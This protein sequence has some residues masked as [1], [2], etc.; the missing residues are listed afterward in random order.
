MRARTLILAAIATVLLCS[1]C[2]WTG[3][4]APHPV[5]AAQVSDWAKHNVIDTNAA[6]VLVTAEWVRVYQAMLKEEGNKL[7][8]S[9]RPGSPND[10]VK[11][12]GSNFRVTFEVSDR[13]ADLKYFERN[14]T[15]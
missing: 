8:V 9:N 2:S 1:S 3:T 5:Q 13:F 6:G 10:G 11:P 7:P 12:E 14:A 4:V 15:P